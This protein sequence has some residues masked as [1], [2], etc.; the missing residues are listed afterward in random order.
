MSVRHEQVA[1][2]QIPNPPRRVAQQK[3]VTRLTLGP[4][5]LIDRADHGVILLRHDADREDFGDRSRITNR[6]DP[7]AGASPQPAADL[8]VMQID[9]APSGR[10]RDPLTEHLHDAVEV[11]A[12]QIA[13]RGRSTT[14]GE[15]FI[16][17]PVLA[18]NRSDDLL[19]EHV[20]RRDGDRHD[21]EPPMTDRACDGHALD[22]LIASQSEHPTLRHQPQRMPRPPDPLQKRGDVPR[23]ADLNHEVDVADVQSHFERRR[24]H[25]RLQLP[26]LQSLLSVMPQIGRQRTVMAGDRL[27]SQQL[28]QLMSQPLRQPPRV[29]KNQRRAVRVHQLDDPL[30][31]LGPLLVH[32]DRPEFA[33]RHFDPQIKLPLK[34]DV[35][36]DRQGRG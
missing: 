36:D 26:G 33:R 7:R 12:R 10:V 22:Q 15:Q 14:D 5:I 3:D 24:R 13:I 30:I 8:I 17:A 16:A 9:A 25:D 31:N 4:E 1:A 11:R 34:A 28:T 32:A 35:D 27:L 23:R 18:S 20:E 29:D 21:V 19:G 6:G 2:T